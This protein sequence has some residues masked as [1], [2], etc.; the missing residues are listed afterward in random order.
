MVGEEFI[1]E[2]REALE[3]EKKTTAEQIRKC[4]EEEL[5]IKSGDFERGDAFNVL[6]VNR[7]NHRGLKEKLEDIESALLRIEAGTYAICPDC[8]QEIPRERLRNTYW[9]KRDAPC[10]AKHEKNHPRRYW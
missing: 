9:L 3:K 7:Q 4:E 6:A 8:N 5:E 2:A 10:Q 1:K